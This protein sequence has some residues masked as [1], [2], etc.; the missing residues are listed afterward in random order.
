VLFLNC[1]P[2]FIPR[3]EPGALFFLYGLVAVIQTCGAKTGRA[4]PVDE[5]PSAEPASAKG[6]C[7]GAGSAWS[8]V[9]DRDNF[10]RLFKI[11]SSPDEGVWTPGMVFL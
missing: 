5:A 7:A 3:A 2:L 1:P 8:G 4:C 9:E 10:Q 11:L 6:A